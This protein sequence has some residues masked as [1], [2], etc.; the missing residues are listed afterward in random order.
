MNKKLIEE[1]NKIS[2][3]VSGVVFG[4]PKIEC[5]IIGCR[6]KPIHRFKWNGVPEKKG[7]GRIIH[8]CKKH[9]SDY[10]DWDGFDYDGEEKCH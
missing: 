1:M 5:N 7:D 10:D 8:T 3:E 2:A 4:K 9:K 6:N